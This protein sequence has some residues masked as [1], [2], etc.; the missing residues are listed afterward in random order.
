MTPTMSRAFDIVQLVNL[1]TYKYLNFFLGYQNNKITQLQKKAISTIIG[2]H[3]LKPK[4]LK[5]RRHFK[6]KTTKI[7]EQLPFFKTQ[8]CVWW[9]FVKFH[10][11]QKK[12]IFSSSILLIAE[13]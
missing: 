8:A 1:I 3:Y 10:P 7:H 12:Y 13:N 4:Q 9:H 6:I 11:A 5:S 2:N